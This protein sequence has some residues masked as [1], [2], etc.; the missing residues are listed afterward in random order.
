MGASGSTRPNATYLPLSWLWQANCACLASWAWLGQRY[1]G[2]RSS[3]RE[4]DRHACFARPAPPRH[5]ERRPRRRL[6]PCAEERTG[7]RAAA[8][9][10]RAQSRQIA[11]AQAPDAPRS[12]LGGRL[13][14]APSAARRACSARGRRGGTRGRFLALGLACG[15]RALPTPRLGG[16]AQSATGSKSLL[17]A[18]RERRLSPQDTPARQQPTLARGSATLRWARCAGYKT[19]LQAARTN[20]GL[21]PGVAH[22]RA[23]ELP[24]VGGRRAARTW[25][26][27]NDAEA[28]PRARRRAAARATSAP[29]QTTVSRQAA[30]LPAEA[31]RRALKSRGQ[32]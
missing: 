31:K 27:A 9:L 14:Q 11:Q 15:L 28:R 23:L 24:M 13:A 26:C 12:T 20:C 4:R 8:G 30:A 7:R 29:R 25:C 22:A 1:A 21:R 3:A 10:L 2:H 19:C 16:E 18:G 17:R 32:I 5:L 6:P